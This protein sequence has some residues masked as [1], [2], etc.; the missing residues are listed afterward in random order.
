[1]C[2][3]NFFAYVVCKFLVASPVKSTWT[4]TFQTFFFSAKNVFRVSSTDPDGGHSHTLQAPSEDEKK[5]WLNALRSVIPCTDNFKAYIWRHGP[6]K[7]DWIA[8]GGATE[9]SAV[10]R[11]VLAY[12]PWNQLLALQTIPNSTVIGKRRCLATKPL[13]TSSV[14]YKFWVEWL[15]TFCLTYYLNCSSTNHFCKLALK[16]NRS[17]KELT[18]VIFN[19]IRQLLP[20]KLHWR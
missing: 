19:C 14:A 7:F 2:Q 1:M 13:T 15:P 16:D 17:P 3:V 10:W 20:L 11:M 12:W 4:W 9:R 5:Q 8:F 6:F 18:V